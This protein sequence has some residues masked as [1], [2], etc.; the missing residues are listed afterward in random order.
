MSY[1]MNSTPTE[2][3][4]E[5]GRHETERYEHAQRLHVLAL[6]LRAAANDR[7]P[8]TDTWW[9]LFVGTVAHMMLEERY[10]RETGPEKY[11]GEVGA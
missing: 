5:I 7:K 1:N 8:K 11:D 9:A 6:A 3:L 10:C 4:A 2:L